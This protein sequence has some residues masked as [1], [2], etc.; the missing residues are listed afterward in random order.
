ML[1][2]IRE[3]ALEQLA[4]SGEAAPLRV[5]HATYFLELAE[6]TAQ[7]IQLGVHQVGL[8]TRRCTVRR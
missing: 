2:V 1:Q 5:A 8:L 4:A 3:A 7:R 6:K